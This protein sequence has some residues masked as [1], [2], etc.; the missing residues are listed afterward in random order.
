MG[1]GCIQ[2]MAPRLY[3]LW[4]FILR[5]TQTGFVLCEAA[6]VPI[7]DDAGCSAVPRE[8]HLIAA[9]SNSSFALISWMW[10]FAAAA[11][12]AGGAAPPR[13]NTFIWREKNRGRIFER[14]QPTPGDA[15]A[16]RVCLRMKEDNKTFLLSLFK[17]RGGSYWCG[18]CGD[19]TGFH[20]WKIRT[21]ITE[22][23]K[24]LLI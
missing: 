19:D 14:L 11:G 6:N 7:F 8:P 20:S 10:S 13:Q 1:L 23:K 12:L 24:V 16:S 17:K 22:Q 3:L 4:P 9:L 5:R 2:Q 15:E 21:I 18:S